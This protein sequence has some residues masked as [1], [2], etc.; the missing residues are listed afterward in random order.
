ME[1]LSYGNVLV[2]MNG[3]VI[4]AKANSEQIPEKFC[5]TCDDEIINKCLE[6]DT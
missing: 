5:A 2:C 1:G 4:T 3:H 6:C